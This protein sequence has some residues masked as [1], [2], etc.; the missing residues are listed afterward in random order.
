MSRRKPAPPVVSATDISVKPG[1]V[2]VPRVN[3]SKVSL[4]DTP[5]DPWLPAEDDSHGSVVAFPTPRKSRRRLYL[6]LGLSTLI[7]LIGGLLAYLIFSPALALRSVEFTGNTLVTSEEATEALEPLLGIPLP[8]ISDGQVEELLDGFAPIESV[9]V[10]AVPPSG[11]AV[12]I[13][14][15]VPVAILQSSGQFL[16]I[17]EDGRQLAS[18]ED[19]EAVQLPLIDGGTDAVNSEVFS[20]IAAVL[21]AL[22]ESILN[23]LNHASAD[24]VDSVELSLAND[25]TIFWGSAEENEAKALVLEALLGAPPADPPAEVFDVSTPSSPVTR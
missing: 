9:T 11:L 21:A 24:S 10:A 15:R 25:Q 23:Q 12:T 13:R 7:L 22:P 18:V 8:Q 5:D 4:L 3:S 6:I 20:S 1:P 2:R 19:R 14:E 16:L 17:D